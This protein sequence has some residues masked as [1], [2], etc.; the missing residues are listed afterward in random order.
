MS[1]KTVIFCICFV[2]ACLF[3]FNH[4][5]TNVDYNKVDS[6][7]TVVKTLEQKRDTIRERIDTTIIKIKENEKYYKEVV[8]NIVTN[9]TD[10]DYI[11]FINY[12]KSNRERYDSN[13]YSDSVKGN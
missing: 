8:N 2:V 9:N 6:L 11:F 13:N 7:E 12:L 4:N 3:F 10:D 1:W 5:K